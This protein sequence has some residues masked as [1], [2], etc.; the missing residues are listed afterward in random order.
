VLP[1]ELGGGTRSTTF[2]RITSGERRPRASVFKQKDLVEKVLADKVKTEVT[3]PRHSE[4]SQL[5]RKA[6]NTHGREQNQ[7]DV[8]HVPERS[9]TNSNT[10]SR[11][12]GARG[13][14][15]CRWPA[16]R[17]ACSFGDVS[18]IV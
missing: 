13:V 2:G 11:G 15:V 1:L 3:D 18:G 8:G 16:R 6:R 5:T 14:D 12:F 4:S 10:H 9:G 7:R 17:A